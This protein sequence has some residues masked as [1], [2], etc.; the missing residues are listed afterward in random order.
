MLNSKLFYY[1]FV[2]HLYSKRPLMGV[3]EQLQEV[4]PTISCG[5]SFIQSVDLI[6]GENQVT[7]YIKS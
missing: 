5:L 3:K 6:L 2:F 4:V 7:Y 1:Q